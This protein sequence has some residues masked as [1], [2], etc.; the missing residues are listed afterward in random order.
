MRLRP[1]QQDMVEHILRHPRS[2]LFA[3]MGAGKSVST[4]TAIDALLLAG[5]INRTLIIAPLRVARDV[6]TD[7]VRKWP[8]LAGLKVVP[9]VGT[10][11]ERIAALA[12]PAQ[13]YT[14]N[15]EQLPWLVERLGNGW[16]FDCVVADELTKLKGVRLRQGN[17]RAGALA[18]VAHT[19][20]KR[21]IG[22]TGTPAPRSLECMWGQMYFIDQGRRLG[23]TYSAFTDRW[24]RSKPGSDPRFRGGLE[25]MP[26]AQGEIQEL[27]KDVCLTL[28][29]KDHFDI[30]DPIVNTL[31]INLPPDARKHYRNMENTMFTELA[32]HE[33]EAFAAAAKTVKLLQ[34][35]SGAAYV[36]GGTDRWVKVHDEKI[37]AL[38]SV[39]EEACGAPILVS[40][41]FKSDLARLLEA[42]PEAVDLSTAAGMKKFKAGNALIGLGH[43]ASMG[44][45]VDGLQR[46]CNILVYFSHDWNLEERLQIAERIG[47]VRQLQAGLVRPV[48]VYNIV[49]RGTVDEVVL[50]RLET[51]RSVQE[52]LMDYM[53][54][55]KND[56]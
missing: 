55:K 41:K 52:T 5:S 42:F 18:Q 38:Q 6:W 46:V 37:A 7:E 8:H 51:K 21:F 17:K 9:I 50:E 13:V 25:A 29:A 49:A 19:R 31:Y 28:D 3:F 30:K 39:V 16:K 22:L 54:A 53:K 14:T 36:D 27:L 2:A 12:T 10:E 20:V 45:G 40:Y 1:Y 33:I 35:A 48:F 56:D 4:L 26:H 34:F 24:F 32:G 23:R 47:P 15:Y 11:K 43:P 44:H